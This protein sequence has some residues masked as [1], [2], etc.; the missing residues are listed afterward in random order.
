MKKLLG[1]LA[2]LLISQAILLFE[3]SLGYTV[4]KPDKTETISFKGDPAELM[5]D[6]HYCF[7][8]KV[9][10]PIDE[11]L[12]P[13][14]LYIFL[15]DRDSCQVRQYT[16]YHNKP[17]DIELPKSHTFYVSLHENQ[18]ALYNWTAEV[19]SNRQ[20]VE[21]FTIDPKNRFENPDGQ[22]IFGWSEGRRVFRFTPTEDTALRRLHFRY[23]DKY[24]DE[25]D[26]KT[27]ILNLHYY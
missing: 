19:W 8:E 12:K 26:P 16:V 10:A 27:L 20:N 11:K 4:Q 14:V 5:L 2:L 9:F 25:N 1:F 24:R 15:Y 6:Y 23:L 21:T 13:E 18:V 22:I 3:P 17:V 7:D